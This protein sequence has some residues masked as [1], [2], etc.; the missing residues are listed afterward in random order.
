MSPLDPS[1]LDPSARPDPTADWWRHAV[2]YQVYPRSFADSDGDGMGDL[3]GVI[4]RL[5]YLAELGVDAL[6]LNP[7]YTSPQKDAGY[8]V[9]DYRQ[10]DP[11]FGTTADAERLIDAAHALGL[12]VIFDIVPN[13]TSSAHPWFVEALAT[14]PGTGIW[15]RYHCV[16]G[17]GEHGQDPPNDWLSVFGG[18]A[19][20][21]IPDPTTGEPSGWWYLHLFDTAQPDLNWNDPEVGAEHERVL[22]F[23]FDRGVDGF[24]IDVAHGLVKTEGYPMS[25]EQPGMYG[26]ELDVLELPQWDQ[27]GVHEVYRAWR[28]VADSYDPPRTFCGEVVVATPEAHAMY[29]RPDELHTAFNFHYLRTR[30][31]AAHLR[32]VIDHS[33]ATAGSVGAPCTWVLSNHDVRRHATRFAPVDDQGT[34]DEERGRARARAATLVMLGLPGSAYLY[35]GEELGLPEVIDLP[36]SARQDPTFLRTDGEVIGRDGCRVP[37]P[38][39]TTPPSFGFSPTG[40]S[41][42]PQPENFSSM[43]VAA[44]DGVEGSTLQMYRDAL[45]IRRTL[46]LGEGS[47]QWH[48]S[49]PDTVAFTRQTTST[50][51]AVVVVAN[52]G[53]TAITWPA[54]TLVLGSSP[55]VTVVDG[56][57]T[58]PPDTAAWLQSA[59]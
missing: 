48:D 28:T 8:D 56:V 22:R 32:E 55:E 10:V 18:L 23:W 54:D 15:S 29:L 21:Q 51:A 52:L 38:W 30:W 37:I 39:T 50:E 7:F 14:P 4:D 25:G 2:I 16:R 17:R 58:L 41:W 12:R 43:S 6:W 34:L 42:L 49:P 24:R 9:A 19:W 40:T 33:L 27:P 13:H 45:G 1:A 5:P 53:E 47:L 59:P 11:R 36:A 26:L 57:A 20:T 44:Q 46:H 3:P 35:Q 31:E